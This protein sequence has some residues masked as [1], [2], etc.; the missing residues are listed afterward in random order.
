MTTPPGWYPDPGHTGDGPAPERWWDGSAWTGQTRAAGGGVPSAPPDATL[1]DGAVPDITPAEGGA[2]SS[3]WAAA[4]LPGNQSLGPP[5][6]GA[7]SPYATSPYGAP[8]YSQQPYGAPPFGPPPANR[9]RATRVVVIIGG[10]AV[11]AALI[12]MAVLLLGDDGDG[13]NTADGASDGPSASQEDGPGEENSP[14]DGAPDGEQPDDGG[15]SGGLTR[16]DGAG[17][18]LP[19]LEGWTEGELP[20]GVAM[21]SGSYTCPGEGSLECVDAG[22]FLT[23]VPDAASLTP[24][25]FARADITPNEETSYSADTYGAITDREEV[26]AEAV[27]VAGQEG[28]RVRSRVETES[29]TSAHVESVA[30]PAPDESGAMVLI[31]LGFDIGDQAPPVEDMDRIV[32]GARAVSGGPGTEA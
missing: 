8:G 23:V 18:A 9:Q 12:V 1:P 6:P 15:G 4:T 29:G 10:L 24:E 16:A 22:V 30:F 27:T 32:L 25:D 26:L 13:S 5:P 21:T 3:P 14:E 31:R 2:P 19:L 11:A 20:G 7:P 28:F 17:V